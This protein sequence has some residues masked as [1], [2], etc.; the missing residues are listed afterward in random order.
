MSLETL[1]PTVSQTPIVA[2]L[3]PELPALSGARQAMAQA[4]HVFAVHAR[5]VAGTAVGQQTT[6]KARGALHPRR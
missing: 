6:F 1:V 3:G 2:Y 5:D 4:A